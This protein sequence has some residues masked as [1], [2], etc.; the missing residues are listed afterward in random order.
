MRLREILKEDYVSDLHDDLDN[1]LI[2]AKAQEKYS[3][4]TP[5]VVDSLKAMG[6]TVTPDSIQ[7]M[8]TGNPLV[9]SSDSNVITVKGGDEQGAESD[10]AEV[11]NM[12]MDAA[13]KEMK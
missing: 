2:S 7:S 10:A 8:L 1:I 5:K 4:S 12:A 13:D 3:L 9:A 11:G 6:Y